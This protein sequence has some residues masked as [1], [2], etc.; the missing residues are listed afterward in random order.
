MIAP[1][2]SAPPIFER[3]AGSSGI[4]MLKLEEKRN[5]LRPNNQNCVVNIPEE[6]VFCIAQKYD[7]FRKELYLVPDIVYRWLQRS[8]YTLCVLNLTNYEWIIGVTFQARIH[9][10]F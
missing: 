8:E 4:S 6:A 7:S 10:N 2:Y 5:E 1:L 3:Y 9:G